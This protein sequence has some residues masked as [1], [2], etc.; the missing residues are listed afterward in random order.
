[1]KKITLLILCSTIV[2]NCFAQILPNR[3]YRTTVFETFR[4]AIITLNNGKLLKQSEANVFLKNG[5]LLY[6]R[7]RLNMEADMRQIKSVQFDDRSFVMVDS[8]LAMVVD[9]LNGYKLLCMSLIDIDAYRTQLLNNRQI[10]NLELREFVNVNGS[11]ASPEVKSS[12]P[13]RNIFFYDI[14][15]KIIKVHERNIKKL[16]KS[17]NRRYYKILIQSPDFSWEDPKSL[18]KLLKLI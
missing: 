16:V 15:G 9:S 5:T 8:A 11:D 4:P 3:I 13:L 7:G 10:T 14:D 18:V 6:K 12:Y 1:M 2:V 17:E